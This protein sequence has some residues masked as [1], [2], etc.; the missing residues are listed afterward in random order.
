MQLGTIVNIKKN[1][2][3]GTKFP[4]LDD[5]ECTI[6]SGLDC[7]IR[8]A[9]LSLSESQVC[10]IKGGQNGKVFIYFFFPAFV[11]HFLLLFLFA[12]EKLIRKGA[13]CIFYCVKNNINIAINSI[14]TFVCVFNIERFCNV[15]LIF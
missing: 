13:Y 11:Y 2:A 6:G 4:L 7:S 14:F 1:G 8:I 9:T 15:L 12:H 3:E 10:A 5:C